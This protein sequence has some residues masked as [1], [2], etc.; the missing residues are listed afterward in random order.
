MTATTE[1]KPKKVI[2]DAAKAAHAAKFAPKRA[3]HDPC[4]ARAVTLRSLAR[5]VGANKLT[6]TAVE[7]INKKNKARIAFIMPRVN[8]LML[9]DPKVKSRIV[10]RHVTA[11]LQLMGKE[12]Y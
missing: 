11:M 4:D 3:Y 10:T 8:A 5:K 2:S 6:A 1:P 7:R 9:R 12:I